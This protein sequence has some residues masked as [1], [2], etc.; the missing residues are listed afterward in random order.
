MRNQIR[1]PGL[2]QEL[3]M[4]ANGILVALMEFDQKRMTNA[5]HIL[6]ILIALDDLALFGGEERLKPIHLLKA[7][8]ENYRGLGS[9]KIAQTCGGRRFA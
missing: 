6:W 5:F 4:R 8:G 1:K 9:D 3:V 7:C 2:G